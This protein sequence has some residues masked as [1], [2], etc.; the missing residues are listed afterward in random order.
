MKTYT[1]KTKLLFRKIAALSLVLALSTPTYVFAVENPFYIGDVDYPV[2]QNNL[3]LDN[4]DAGGDVSIQFGN[5]LNEVLKFDSGDSWFN[6]SDDINVEGTVQSGAI[7]TFADT[8][9]DADGSSTTGVGTANAISEGDT[10]VVVESADNLCTN[11]LTSPTNL[12]I[13][14]NSNCADTGADTVLLGDGSGTTAVGSTWAFQDTV[15]AN[16]AY[17][18]GEDLYIDVVA[19]L[20]YDS[21]NVTAGGDLT[22]TD[23]SFLQ[24]P[25][26]P[27]RVSTL[28]GASYNG[29]RA[30]HVEGRIAYVL[31]SSSL[32]AVDIHE[33][34]NPVLLGSVGAGSSPIDLFISGRYAYSTDSSGDTLRIYDI[35]NPKSLSLVGTT[36]VNGASGV[37]VSGKYAYV[38][39]GITRFHV[40]DVSDPENPAITVDQQWAN[41]V[42]LEQEARQAIKLMFE[43]FYINPGV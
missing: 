25:G 38:A 26:N 30:V 31:T 43:T 32:L 23:G 14:A 12:R 7:V 39:G 2:K 40:I 41:R 29:A 36:G 34:D 21:G 37:Y 16:S 6:F 9:A 20:A 27:V 15:T 13:D 35:S 4:N 1:K 18:D 19:N 33:P 28:S 22:V 3:I 17:T 11:S 5:T 42:M 24:T 10:L 8:L